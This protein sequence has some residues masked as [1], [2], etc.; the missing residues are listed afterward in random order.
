MAVKLFLIRHGQT[1]W[2]RQKRYCGLVDIGLNEKGKEQAEKLC[3]KLKGENISSVYASDLKRTAVFAG[4]VFPGR[5]IQKISALR[6][7]D[8]G[9]FE[10][11]T[12]REIMRKHASLYRAWLNDPVHT[13]IP[14]GETITSLMARVKDAL[15]GILAQHKDESIAICSH[16][17]PLR[18]ILCDALQMPAEKIREIKQ[19]PA[20]FN[21]INYSSKGAE[22]LV[23]NNT[24]YQHE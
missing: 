21:V 22:V 10:G 13:R 4:I 15:V 12:H 24:S 1:E 9:I 20:C 8:F 18:V 19:D 6:E 16:A 11:L 2:T 14:E 7:V 3:K 23:F 5:R 17:G